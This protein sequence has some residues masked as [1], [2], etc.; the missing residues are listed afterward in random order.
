MNTRFVQ[1]FFV[2]TLAL[3]AACGVDPAAPDQAFSTSVTGN[4]RVSL[5]LWQ[6]DAYRD[7]PVI[8]AG[9]PQHTTVGIYV[10]DLRTGVATLRCE[11][12][13]HGSAI[14]SGLV[15][16]TE[17][18]ACPFSFESQAEAEAFADD[19]CSCTCDVM[20]AGATTFLGQDV[21]ADLIGLEQYLRQVDHDQLNGLLACSPAAG[22][23]P[24]QRLDDLL[25][26]QP[27]DYDGARALLATQ[28][29]PQWLAIPKLLLGALWDSYHVCNNDAALEQLACTTGACPSWPADAARIAG[30]CRGPR[31]MK[32]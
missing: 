12:D 25:T 16:P 23:D 6:K 31:V 32:P 8:T 13:N 4:Y 9:W 26:A 5:Q 14:A 1:T 24:T 27:P 2:L 22:A 3:P 11:A 20:G 30:T 21:E 10:T 17:K 7:V 29:A 18:Q 28:C 19:L 15:Q